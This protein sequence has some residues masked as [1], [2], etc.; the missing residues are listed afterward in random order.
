MPQVI[1]ERLHVKEPGTE[2]LRRS[3]AGHLR[4]LIATGWRETERWHT[5]GYV[6]VRME[7]EGRAPERIPA[8]PV[9]SQRPRPQGQGNYRGRPGGR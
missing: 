4:H 9:A 1:H 2:R 5:P 8:P 3:A 6:T 7:R